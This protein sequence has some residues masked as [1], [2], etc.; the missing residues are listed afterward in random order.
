MLVH[1]PIA[2]FLTRIRNAQQR[3]KA[4]LQVPATKVLVS[5]AEIL[6]EEGFIQDFEIVDTQP[7]RTLE[8]T[9]KYVNGVAA[10]RDLKRV[11]KP[12]IRRYVGYREVPQIMRGLGIAILSTPKGI[13]TGKRARAE[14]VGGEFLCT[15]Y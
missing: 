3:E 7:Q 4:S 10:I 11:S 2:D 1:D 12:G 13:M 14:K 6:K 8:V 15:I 9:L 5:I